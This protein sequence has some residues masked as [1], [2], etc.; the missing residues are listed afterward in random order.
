[1]EK[2]KDSKQKKEPKI[3]TKPT[4]DVILVK[5]TEEKIESKIEP[6]KRIDINGDLFINGTDIMAVL[7]S[8][9]NKI[10]E[11]ITIIKVS[12][13]TDISKMTT[14]ELNHLREQ[15]IFSKSCLLNGI[16]MTRNG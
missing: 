9:A 5:P 4:Q 11:I 15:S 3:N 8:I 6:N 2:K 13:Q 12:N 1:M 7:S 10:D 14:S 16:L